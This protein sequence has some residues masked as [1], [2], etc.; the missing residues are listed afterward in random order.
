MKAADW[1]KVNKFVVSRIND[2]QQG[3]E[4]N[5]YVTT[6]IV[7]VHGYPWKF[8]SIGVGCQLYSLPNSHAFR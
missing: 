3:T 4:A 8:L 7:A 2:Y 6:M 1:K 5:D